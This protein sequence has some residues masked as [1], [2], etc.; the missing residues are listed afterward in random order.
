MISA[1]LRNGIKKRKSV[2]IQNKRLVS[3]AG[4]DIH[5]ATFGVREDVFLL[6]RS[7][8]VPEVQ[9]ELR[10]GSTESMVADNTSEKSNIV[11]I[12]E[13]LVVSYPAVDADEKALVPSEKRRYFG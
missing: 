13:A 8:S 3:K 4:V 7:H 11:F 9:C 6:V 2:L 1:A 10:V 5:A 12:D